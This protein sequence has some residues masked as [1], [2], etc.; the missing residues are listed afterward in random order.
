MGKNIADD[1]P[2]LVI[3]NG[4]EGFLVLSVKNDML[5]GDTYK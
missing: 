1:L 4:K 2:L 5:L 3:L